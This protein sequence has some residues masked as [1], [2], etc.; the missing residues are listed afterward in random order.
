MEV[1]PRGGAFGGRALRLIDRITFA[2]S[3]R[4]RRFITAVLVAHL[5]GY[6]VLVGSGVPG[7]ETGL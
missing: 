4:V 2:G 3:L 5:A 6:F 7:Q 1:S